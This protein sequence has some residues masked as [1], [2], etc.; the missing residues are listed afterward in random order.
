MKQIPKFLSSLLHEPML[1][2]DEGHIKFDAFI[3][4]VL[5][6]NEVY[7]QSLYSS[8]TPKTIDQLEFDADSGIG[9]VNVTGLLVDKYDPELKWWYGE[10]GVTSYQELVDDVATLLEAGAHTIIQYSYTGGGQVYN[11]FNTSNRI[12]NMLDEKDAVMITYSDGITASGGIVLAAPSDEIVAH[13]DSRVG[14]VGVVVSLLDTSKYMEELG[15]KRIFITAGKNKVHLNE[16]GEFTK[17]YL[18]E[19]QVGVNKT[20]EKFVSHITDNRP[21]TREQLI[22]VGAKVFDADDALKVGYVDKIMTPEEF[23]NYFESDKPKG[24]QMSILDKFTKTPKKETQSM[25]HDNPI[26]EEKLAEVRSAIEA[27]Y[28]PKLSELEASLTQA[29]AE[30][31]AKISERDAEVVALKASLAAFEKEK[32]DKAA[33]AES[34]KQATRL[35][36]L[37]EVFGDVEGEKLSTAYAKLPDEVFEA[38]LSVVSGKVGSLEEED[39][40]AGEELDLTPK[41]KAETMAKFLAEKHGNKPTSPF[42]R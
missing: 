32:A 37:K 42:K 30:F 22:E 14:S 28:A 25:S 6:S 38:T 29:K 39:G 10:D 27:E 26:A 23:A 24:T 11:A 8:Y 15:V 21:T 33:E 5:N 17:E 20:Y 13:P 3:D 40:D 7:D 34:A 1:L 4:K 35:A 19:L 2:S 18:E 12:R 41:T 9:V 31:E 36:Q 16:K